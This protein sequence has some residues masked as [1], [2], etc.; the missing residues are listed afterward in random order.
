MRVEQQN[1]SVVDVLRQDFG[2]EEQAEG[3]FGGK[4]GITGSQAAC[5]ETYTATGHSGTMSVN[6]RDATYQKPGAEEEKTTVEELEQSASMDAAE[7]K[8]Q[9]TVLAGTTSQEDY[10]RMQKEGFSLDESSS[11]T[12]ITVTDKIKAEL[13]KA[14]VDI[15]VFGDDLNMEQ[16]EKLA[17][18]PEFARQLAE[19]FREAD[20]PANEGNIRDAV[21][22]M[23]MA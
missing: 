3:I 2:P 13:A 20:I 7:R 18:S 9:M 4:A 5:S 15:S 23:H 14:G 6:M 22:A 10:A 8:N 17:G 16:L 11:N 21:D 12:I 1:T 19:A